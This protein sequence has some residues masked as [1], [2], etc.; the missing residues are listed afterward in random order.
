MGIL[1]FPP[2]DDKISEILYGPEKAVGRGVYFMENVKEKMDIFFDKS[3]PSIVVEL[4]EYKEGYK[5]IRERGGKIRAFTEITKEN[6]SYCKDLI[7]LVDELR[8][9][10]G[11]RGGVA[12]S[13]TEYMATTILQK[14]T[15]LTEV[16]YSSAK[17]MV[18]SGQYIF[19]TF[20]RIAIPAEQKIKE[21]EEGISPEVIES[22]TDAEI[23]QNKV[24]DLLRDA[25]EEILVL[26]STANAFHRQEQTG[27][28]Q[29]LEEI[30]DIN[31]QIKIKIL[32]PK[33][34]EIKK[35]CRNL[36]NN[37]NVLY[38]FVEPI[39]KVSILVVDRKFSIVVELKDDTKKI[40]S[41]AIGLAAYSNS[42]PTVL[43]YATIFDVIWKQIEL[44]E[45]LRIHER[46]QK[47]FINI[48]AH[49]L[50]API[51][52]IL[53]CS[54]LLR[55]KLQNDEDK[56]LVEIIKRNAQRSLKMSDDILDLRRI[57]TNSL[58]LV[59]ENFK[60]KE[61][62]LEIIKNYQT[63][64]MKKNLVMTC[65]IPDNLV[66]YGDKN[67]ITE[68]I[69]NLISNSIKFSFSP[70]LISIKAEST[71]NVL[72]NN[73]DKE[74]DSDV[75]ISVQDRGSGIDTG[76]FDRLFTKFTTNSSQG[77]GLGLYISKNIVE[78]H[79]GR[80][81]AKNNDDGKGATF[82]FGLPL[83]RTH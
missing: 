43:T 60:V 51:Q 29:I 27:S 20:W 12:V 70:I 64:T 63:D 59:K 44:Y 30:K 1:P 21:I 48:A 58:I 49:E 26:F 73:N 22:I 28:I 16:I 40:M 41:E 10:D 69:S 31:P 7:N 45:Q 8:H 11:V 32:T 50:K 57:E 56:E 72:L 35:T 19:D 4:L 61:L 38:R 6:S 47:E 67:R 76:I 81:W 77:I 52:P 33:D 3:A 53:S 25:N 42:L 66:V 9:L 65:D 78:A 5:K 71:G 80:I 34:D 74:I 83:Y 62:V 14:S 18:E 2:K 37:Y 54:F 82:G 39:S 24:V 36:A 68:V 75:I 46:I 13:E 17:E 15:P 23:L 79:G 55:N